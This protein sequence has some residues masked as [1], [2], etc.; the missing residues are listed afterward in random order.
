MPEDEN[1]L[2][3]M[4]VR[5]ATEKESAQHVP[6]QEKYS[7]RMPDHKEVVSSVL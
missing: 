4:A 3:E 5:K 1:N 2:L 7:V 6:W